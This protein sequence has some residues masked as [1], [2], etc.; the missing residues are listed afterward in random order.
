MYTDVYLT[1]LYGFITIISYI[2]LRYLQKN[3]NKL[4]YLL[5]RAHLHWTDDNE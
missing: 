4:I 3:R 2:V 1:D 5:F